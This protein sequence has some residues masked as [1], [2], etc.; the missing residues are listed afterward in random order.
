MRER[1][2]RF[3]L[4][5]NNSTRTIHQY[6]EKLDELGIK[7]EPEQIL[8]SAYATADWLTE[9]VEPRTTI[10]VAGEDGLHH[11]L[12]Q[13]GYS[14]ISGKDMDG[15]QV[16]A[17]GLHLRF[18][19][20]TLFCATRLIR[21][22]ALYVGTNP[23]LTY[24]LPDGIGPGAGSILAAITAAS[25]TQPTIIG[26][27]GTLMFEQALKSLDA[28]PKET[29]M[30]GDRLETDILGGINAGLS[31]ILVLSGV[32]QQD[33]LAASDI[34]PTWVYDDT[35]PR[36]QRPS[37]PMTE[38]NTEVQTNPNLYDLTRNQLGDLLKSL[39]QP[40][41]RADQLWEWLYLQKA[42]SF[43]EMTNLP[44]DLRHTLATQTRLGGLD[45]VSEQHSSDGET[46][47]FLLRLPDG[48][49]IESVIMRYD[50]RITAC[51]STQAG[52]ALGCVF[53]ATGQMGFERNL[54]VGEIVEQVVH[55]ARLLQ[56]ENQRLSNIVMMGMGEPFHN[57]DA[58]L[59]AL[60]RITDQRALSIG[61]RHV[62]VSTVGLVPQIRSFA[63]ANT[64]VHLA[65]S[66]HA[67][68]DEKRSALLPINQRYP[69]AELIGACH[70]YTETT[71]RRVMIEWAVI[72]GQNDTPQEAHALGKLLQDL[73]CI[74]NLIPLN[75][76]TGYEG[77]PPDRERIDAF[78]AI[79]TQ[80]K[81]RSTVRLRRGIDIDAGCG[82]LKATVEEKT[83]QD[84]I[85]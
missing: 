76:T 81:I 80:Y 54:S 49:L 62:T 59:A 33:D 3:M 63:E 53:C 78:R 37:T 15:A 84:D 17:V 14:I 75:P 58:T 34:K 77:Q 55:I 28:Q 46:R 83:L 29:A 13:A 10:Y 18:D 70:Y 30:L 4:L 67:A 11:A 20:P 51:I 52:C 57:Y 9:R 72:A 31:T 35:S 61:Q 8:T 24:P 2:M 73:H 68:T 79:L 85:S 71:G 60:D 1:D 21:D 41:Y 7:V 43:E 50:N 38:I 69:L 12:K 74:V 47:K 64:Q 39:S 5:T 27:P 45:V 32:T 65:I 48:Q 23:D 25:G 66:L 16:V 6:V 42:A 19:Y 36:W 82:Q 44:S 40:R 26:K 56:Q 22:G